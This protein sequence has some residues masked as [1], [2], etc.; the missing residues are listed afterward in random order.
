VPGESSHKLSLFRK[1]KEPNHAATVADGI[2]RVADHN[3]E[4]FADKVSW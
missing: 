4:S 1:S 3:G 2:S